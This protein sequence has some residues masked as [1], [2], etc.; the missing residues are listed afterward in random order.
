MELDDLKLAWHALDARLARHDQLQLA[1]LHDRRID[2]AQRNLRPLKWGMAL[3]ALLGL[4]LVL[5][6]I[7]CWKQNPGVPG[8]LVAGIALHVFGVLHIALAGIVAGLASTVDYDSPVLVIQKRL[9]MLL[10][11]QVLNSNVCGLPWWVMWVVVVV[12]F[13][14]LSPVPAD[15]TTPAWIWI[16]LALGAVGMAATWAWSVRAARHPDALH[17]RIDDGADGIRRNLRLFDDIDRFE[18]E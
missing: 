15:A 14:G 9:R 17:A 5:L 18:R 1:M 3:Q 10:R 8:L 11:M 2:R 6:G 12:G 16:S 4:G 7:G 13:A